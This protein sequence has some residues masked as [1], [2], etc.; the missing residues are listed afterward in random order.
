MHNLFL[1]N[2]PSLASLNASEKRIRI[3]QAVKA[4]RVIQP[5][6][7]NKA[8]MYLVILIVLPVALLT[9]YFSFDVAIIWALVSTCILNFISTKKEL[10]QVEPYLSRQNQTPQ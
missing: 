6:N 3:A 7:Q 5:V 8:I 4:S 2:H 9:Y 10:K 1:W